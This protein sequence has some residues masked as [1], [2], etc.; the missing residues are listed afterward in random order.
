MHYLA[1]EDSS[2]N[3]VLQK[4]GKGR[5]YYRIGMNYAPK[6]LTLDPADHGFHVERNY[7]GMDDKEDVVHRKDGVWEI[8]S[9]AK[10][11]VTVKMVAS[12]RRYHVAL[13]DPLPA[14]LE[15]LNPAIAVTGELPQESSQNR[16]WWWSRPWYEHKN[17]RDE[18][19]EAFSSLV[20]GGVYEYVY[21]ARATTP[22]NF[23]VL[24]QKQ[25][26]CMHQRHSGDPGRIG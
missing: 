25:K 4:D 1:D 12:G 24:R 6:N 16:F 10:V 3:L 18:R 9:G 23:V 15:V 17:M 14:G 22:G 26:K 7:E 13:V 2:Q 21:Y 19:V 11:K 20:Y 5:M 8:R